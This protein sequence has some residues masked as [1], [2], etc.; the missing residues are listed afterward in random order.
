[1]NISLRLIVLLGFA[2]WM[3]IPGSLSAQDDDLTEFIRLD[4]TKAIRCLVIVDFIKALIDNLQKGLL[5]DM[6]SNLS[7]VS[8]DSGNDGVVPGG[9]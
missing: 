5:F 1:M 3:I 7:R 4:D 2:L 6:R 8:A 9:R